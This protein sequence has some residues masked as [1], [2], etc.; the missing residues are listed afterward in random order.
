MSPA[1][2]HSPF[3]PAVQE[4]A[5]DAAGERSPLRRPAVAAA[6]ALAA[7]VIGGGAYLALGG[8][9][10]TDVETGVPPVRPPVPAGTASAA[11][12]AA[13]TPEA[14]SAGNARNPFAGN[15]SAPA[16]DPGTAGTTAPPAPTGPPAPAATA[17]VAGPTVTVPGPT[18][19]VTVT[20][21]SAP[22]YLGLYG[23][24]SNGEGEF[25][26]NDEPAYTVAPGAVFAKKFKFVQRTTSSPF[27][28]KVLYGDVTT[29]L[30]A[31]D[32]KR[33]G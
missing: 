18:T 16:V 23:V 12:P 19:T 22:V 5:G 30:C 14:A 13:A 3:R 33:V 9:D 8:G 17:T 27:C 11:P 10:G 15:S 21:G 24:T 25:R 31:G 29:T 6:A 20:A 1:A 2:P 32:V 7:V 26:V 28:A 4:P